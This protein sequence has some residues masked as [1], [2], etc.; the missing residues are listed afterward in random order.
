[1]PRQ[2]E[3]RSTTVYIC[4][5]IHLH[6]SGPR[7]N[8][9]NNARATNREEQRPA[10]ARMM[11]SVVPW[12]NVQY[13]PDRVSNR[14]PGYTYVHRGRLVRR[15]APRAGLPTRFPSAQ[16]ASYY[17]DPE[18][19][20]PNCY[21]EPP[22]VQQPRDPLRQHALNIRRM[23]RELRQLRG[24]PEEPRRRRRNHS[25]ALSSVS[26]SSN[27]SSTSS[28]SSSSD[29]SV[30]ARFSSLPRRPAGSRNHHCRPP[31]PYPWQIAHP[32]DGYN[33]EYAYDYR[34][35]QRYVPAIP[36]PHSIFGR[37]RQHSQPGVYF[38]GPPTW[39]DTPHFDPRRGQG[40]V[41]EP[42]WLSRMTRLS[43]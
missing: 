36:Q 35:D 26:S 38:A 13:T 27:S 9:P 6:S 22:Q 32:Y 11:A 10:F 3:R 42:R 40:V 19:G 21:G 5:P 34:L 41:R 20:W 39:Q 37:H 14:D 25:P 4:H 2:T 15:A 12:F 30:H 16:L 7:R 24:E 33:E 1:M 31:S 43:Q 8:Q 29:S 28:S 23:E 18:Y 17:P